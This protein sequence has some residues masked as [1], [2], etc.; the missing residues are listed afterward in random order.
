MWYFSLSLRLL[1][2][3]VYSQP[4]YIV[5]S[6]P[7][8]FGIDSQV[9]ERQHKAQK[10]VQPPATH[11]EFTARSRYKVRSSSRKLQ[12]GSFTTY[13]ASTHRNTLALCSGSQHNL[14]F[15]TMECRSR[16]STRG[17]WMRIGIEDSVRIYEKRKEKHK[18]NSTKNMVST[19]IV[20]FSAM[21]T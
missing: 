16:S 5:L 18:S 21:A 4:A 7:S 20:L 10:P 2:F 13:G 6:G 12:G 19:S 11:S 3:S 17:L 8:V 14:S 15:L 1:F 9:R